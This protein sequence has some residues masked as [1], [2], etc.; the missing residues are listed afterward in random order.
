MVGRDERRLDWLTCQKME[1]EYRFERW[2]VMRL[3]TDVDCK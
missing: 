2:K 1:V 3:V